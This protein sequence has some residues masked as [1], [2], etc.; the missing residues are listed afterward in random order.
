MPT[1]A[2]PPA[3]ACTAGRAVLTPLPSRRRLVTRP[4]RRRTPR[5]G[6][7]RR[8]AGT[9]APARRRA[10]RASIA[11]SVPFAQVT[12]RGLAS[13]D[14][15]PATCPWPGWAASSRGRRSP[16]GAPAARRWSG[17]EQLRTPDDGD[18]CP[19]CAPRWPRRSASARCGQRPP[20][21]HRVGGPPDRLGLLGHDLQRPVAALIGEQTTTRGR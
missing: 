15:P 6:P 5:T 21:Q 2:R 3:R 16:R 18:R 8:S 4:A 19:P 12:V 17:S 14:A 10:D 20:G 7:D 11:S 13:C 9:C 1:H